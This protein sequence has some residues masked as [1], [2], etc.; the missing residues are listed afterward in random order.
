MERGRRSELIERYRDGYRVVAEAVLDLTD[1]QL[2][3]RPADG[4]WSAR[5]VVH[6]L[7]DSEMMSAIRLR[8]LIAEERPAIQGYDEM[9]FAERLYYDARPIAASLDA[10]K[11]ARATSLEILERLTEA[12]W[13]RAGTHSESGAY[14]GGDVARD[15]RGACP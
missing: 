11:A 3:R 6:H 14:F 8:R 4:G 13:A 12:E 7:A 10:L 5:R 9:E 2:D 15:L 1:G